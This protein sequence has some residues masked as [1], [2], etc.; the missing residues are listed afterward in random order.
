MATMWRPHFG[1]R[2]PNGGGGHQRMYMWLLLQSESVCTQR[3]LTGGKLASQRIQ[4]QIRGGLEVWTPRALS[5][6]RTRS[7]LCECMCR[8]VNTTSPYMIECV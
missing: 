7:L 3:E 2:N 4:G 8:G 5:C 1:F 6:G